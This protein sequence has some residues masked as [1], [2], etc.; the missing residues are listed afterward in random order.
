MKHN[1]I[2]KI[3][4]IGGVLLG[5]AVI[6]LAL[7]A[8][9]PASAASGIALSSSVQSGFP[10]SLTFNVKAQGDVNVTQLRVH[11]TVDHQTLADVTSEGWAAFTPATSVT[12]QWVWDMRRTSLPPGAKVTYWWTALDAAGK[13]AQTDPA[14]VSFDDTRFKWQSVT[15]GPV[16]LEWYNGNS[17]FANALMT[18]A[19]DGLKR[20]Q[21]NTGA[22]PTGNVHIYIYASAADLQSAQLFAQEWEGGVTFSGYD[23]IAVGVPTSQLSYGQTAVPHEL[24]HWIVGQITFNKYGAGLPT[25]LDEGLATYGE[26]ALNPS[27]QSALSN[28]IKNN[29]LLSVRTLSSPF[30]ADTQTAYISYGESDS[31][32]T[33]MI[34]NYGKDKMNQ[35]LEVFRQGSTYDAALQQVYGFDQDGLDK[36]WRQSLGIKMVFMPQMEPALAGALSP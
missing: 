11:Y 4:I 21:N 17:S 28:A 18:A 27:Y 9:L 5:L 8:R 20:I 6:I 29:Q 35:L 24:T 23:I 22:T 34:N 26:G 25:W 30:S 36:V 31:I 7:G 2:I 13:T 3:K 16:T 33:F 1:S 32:V 19:Q 15:N 12:T 14:T 10:N